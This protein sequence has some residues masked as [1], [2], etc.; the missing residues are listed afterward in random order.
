MD[1][2]HAQRQVR[3]LK[4]ERPRYSKGI[5]PFA[6]I[7]ASLGIAFITFVWP[8][9]HAKPR[10]VVASAL[11]AVTL[12]AVHV[13]YAIGV[14]RCYVRRAQT[15]PLLAEMTADM[16]DRFARE[17]GRQALNL[18]VPLLTDMKFYA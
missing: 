5:I 1:N 7:L 10:L 15:Y 12:G 11:V 4:I 3:S 14:I 16:E 13:P 9:L 6:V 2:S 18:R 17:R 8:D